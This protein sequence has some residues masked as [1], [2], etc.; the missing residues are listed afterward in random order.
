MADTKAK[1]IIDTDIGDDIDDALAIAL[2]LNWPG[3]DL[4]GITTVF[5]NVKERARL[6]LTELK[7]YNRDIPVHMGIGH[8]LI[9]DAD[10][11]A[12][13]CQCAAA[14]KSI[15]VPV[16][17]NAV[18]FI[19][20]TCMSSSDLITLVPIGPLTNIAAA[21]RL[22]PRLAQKVRIVLMGGYIGKPQPEWNI[23]CDPEAAHIVMSSGADIT[24]VGLD[25]T[26]RCQM[27]PQHMQ[28]FEAS[29]K[30]EIRFLYELIKL[31][32][33]S[34]VGRM[35]ILHDPLA[36]TVALDPSFVTL[37]PMDIQ[38]ELVGHYTRGM[39][40]PKD[41]TSVK[42]AVDV[43]VDRFMKRFMDVVA[44]EI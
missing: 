26:M 6:A 11:G 32:Q 21:L 43:D 31:W 22:E 12:I 10:L 44:G 13:P 37:K 27:Q 33:G 9:N 17:K 38:I 24:M 7:V 30:P 16:G 1:L 18:D 40:M 5:R 8:P 41:G 15:E 19:I 39:T 36:V 29:S 34:A 25:V 4:I 20:D 28:A 35:P 42:A 3:A 2:A 14:D 23:M